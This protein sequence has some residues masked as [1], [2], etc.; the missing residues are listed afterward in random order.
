MNGC[1]CGF[2]T[3][4]TKQCRCTPTKIHKYLSKISGPLL[5]RIDIHI[6]VPP[7]KYKELTSESQA[8]SSDTIKSR[9]NKAR[10]NQKDRFSIGTNRSKSNIFCNAQMN[11]RQIRQYCT[12]NEEVKQLLKMAVNELG[13]SARAYDKILKISRTIADLAQKPNILPEHVSEAIQYRS[14]DRNLWF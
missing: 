10:D 9:V 1:P 2:F 13:F 5:D 7:L 14:L 4:P 11:H 6:E 12:I 3:D 8:E